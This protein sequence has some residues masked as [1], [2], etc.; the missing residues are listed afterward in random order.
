MDARPGETRAVHEVLAIAKQVVAKV[1]RDQITD[2]AGAMTYQSLMALFPGLL[3][4]VS[5]LGLAGQG[6]LYERVL[7]QAQEVA[8]PDLIEPIEKLLA[9]VTADRSAAVWT[10]VLALALGLN[11]ASGALAAAGNGL[12][13]VLGVSEHR[14][15]VERKL[16]TLGWTL[17]LIVLVLAC[18]MLVFAGGDV[19]GLV[20]RAASAW[21]SSAQLVWSIVRWP[22]AAAVALGVYAIVYY[23]APDTEQRRF[24]Y[25]TPGAVTGVVLWIAGSAVFFLWVQSFDSYS[26][27]YGTFATAVVLLIWLYLSNIALLL[28]AELNAVLDERRCGVS[29]APTGPDAARQ[30]AGRG[31]DEEPAAPAP[32][33]PARAASP[34]WAIAA[35]AL[36]ALRRPR[37]R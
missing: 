8:P 11:G 10:T 17:V 13:A 37:T 23:V 28:G 7:E 27:T 30:R 32:R 36:A 25:I 18:C 14:G 12:N 4:A 5:L 29:H 16:R 20:P 21:G 24:R 2:R 9:N 31:G 19:A 34:V 1:Q 26:R 6:A 15:W 35:L 3:L 33:E 22:A